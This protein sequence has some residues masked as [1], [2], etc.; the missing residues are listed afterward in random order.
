MQMKEDISVYED[1][2]KQA[3]QTS[4]AKISLMLSEWC[5]DEPFY[6][7]PLPLYHLIEV[8]NKHLLRINGA[9]LEYA[10]WWSPF[11]HHDKF[12]PCDWS[13]GSASADMV[14]V[15][16]AHRSL[17]MDGCMSAINE[18]IAMI[19]SQYATFLQMEESLTHKGPIC[20]QLTQTKLLSIFGQL[21]QDDDEDLNP[22]GKGK[23][24]ARVQ[25][26]EGDDDGGLEDM[27][28]GNDCD[29]DDTS[30]GDIEQRVERRARVKEQAAAHRQLLVKEA[31]T[32]IMYL[33][34]VEKPP[35][36]TP[37][38]FGVPT[39][40]L[41]KLPSHVPKNIFHGQE[42]VV[43]HTYEWANQLPNS[44]KRFMWQ[45]ACLAIYEHA[46]I[47]LYCP[48]LLCDIA[49]EDCID[50]YLIAPSAS[51][52]RQSH[53]TVS[54]AKSTTSRP[55][56][57]HLVWPDGLSIDCDGLTL[58]E[59]SIEH[60]LNKI[61][62]KEL[63]TCQETKLQCIIDTIQNMSIL[64]QDL[65]GNVKVRKHPKLNP[66]VSKAM[67]GLVQSRDNNDVPMWDRISAM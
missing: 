20:H 23:A 4:P 53:L 31:E 34:A 27:P 25:D 51:Q 7:F 18:I 46:I 8:M 17:K 40:C 15:V 49:S 35:K 6:L 59:F 5:S 55:P 37:K 3:I 21:K 33:N 58:R 56:V 62:V 10:S 57:P 39:D 45:L 61:C 16:L 44:K 36:I 38:D 22:K 19:F 13:P 32:A 14:R 9:L 42:F 26:D 24:K 29:D 64:W 2:V 1:D 66:D 63:K 67:L 30:G 54:L 12:H 43:H 48:Q 28:V 11:I 65:T 50:E 52:L 41:S 60:Q 47:H